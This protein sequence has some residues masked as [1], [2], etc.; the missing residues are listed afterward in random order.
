MDVMDYSLLV[1]IARDEVQGV[2]EHREDH[3]VSRILFENGVPVVL[4][5]DSIDIPKP[6]F[7]P[8]S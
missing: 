4:P 2:Q 8:F 7:A 5:L 3:R 1:G 6:R